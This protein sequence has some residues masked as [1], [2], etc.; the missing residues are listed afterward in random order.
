MLDIV[1]AE[2]IPGDSSRFCVQQRARFGGTW[3]FWAQLMALEVLLFALA[4]YKA[5]QTYREM[6]TVSSSFFPKTL[7]VLIRDSMLYFLV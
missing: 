1:T 4:A 5:Y 2:S 7:H 3:L 6:E